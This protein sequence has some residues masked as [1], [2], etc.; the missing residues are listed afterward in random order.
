[1][2]TVAEG[3]PAR[4]ARQANTLGTAGAPV[5][6]K[7]RRARRLFALVALLLIGAAGAAAYAMLSED[8]GPVT[9]TVAAGPRGSDSYT[10]M[11]ETAAVLRRHSETLRLDVRA[12]RGSSLNMAMLAG[13]RVDL[14]TIRSDTPLASDVRSVADLFPDYF[15]L[16]TAPGA[17]AR[18]VNDLEGLRVAIPPDGTEQNHTFHM[19]LDHYDVEASSV[20][21]RAM[22]FPA[23]ASALLRGDVDVLFTV[24]SLRDGTLVRLFEDAALSRKNLGLVPIDQAPAIALKRPF[25]TAAII[26]RGAYTGRNPTPRSDTT[27]GSVTRVLVTR[28]DVDEEAINELASVMF[29]HR[30][31]LTIRFALAA[32]VR[33]PGLLG[34][35]TANAPIHDGVEQ[36]I[37][38]DEPS[39]IQENAEPLALVVTVSSIL[40][41]MLFGLRARLSS[42][43]KNRLDAY[44]YDLLDIGERARATD[45]PT[46]LSAMRDE[47]FAVLDRVVRALDTDEVTEEG[48]QSF[49]LLWDSVRRIIEDRERLLA[50]RAF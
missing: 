41:S 2:A 18:S 50:T 4:A 48:F 36:W 16:I 35:G 37:N 45:D 14:A 3:E 17:E 23:A 39:F 29:G 10:L 15:Q 25:V 34:G 13:G 12:T 1:M 49:S 40:V 7:A 32:A 5:K 42:V 9:L 21:W 30:L 22:P 27:T 19:L 20:R 33:E 47:H 11:A 44:N 31:D 38:R 28:E 46:A 26:P 6:A 24:R 43:Q 8:T